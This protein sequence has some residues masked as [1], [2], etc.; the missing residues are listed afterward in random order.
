MGSLLALAAT[1][2]AATALTAPTVAPDALVEVLVRPATT[3]EAATG[4]ITRLG[5]EVGAL[6]PAVGLIEARVPSSAIP[7]LVADP[8]VASVD[9]GGH[10]TFAGHDQAKADKPAKADK[11]GKPA[12]GRKGASGDEA[13]TDAVDVEGPTDVAVDGGAGWSSGGTTMDV[14]NRTIG[15]TALHAQ[16]IDGRGI[17]IALVDTGVGDVPQLAGRW[18]P[19]I[20]LSLDAADPARAGRDGYGHGTHLAGIM[21][22]SG[23]GLTGVAPGARIVDVRVGDHRGAADVSQMVAAIDWVIQNARTGGRN[24]RVLNLAFGTTTGE[25][26][27][28]PLVVAVEAAQR[29]GIVVVVSAGNDGPNSRSLASP[30]TTPLAL[31]VGAS[32]T[33]GTTDRSD[34]T[35]AEFSQRG[36]RH[37]TPDLVAPGRSI[38]SVVPGDALV[39]TTHPDAYRGGLFLGSGTS[40]AAAVTSG[41]A[42]LLLQARPDLTPDALRVALTGTADSLVKDDRL[43]GA[44]LLDV[45]AAHVA[46]LSAPV[47][48]PE[49]TA[50]V[51]PGDAT[52]WM[53]ANWNGSVWA[54]ANW[55]EADWAGGN[56]NGGNWNGGNWNGGNWNGGNWNGGN[57]NEADWSG[58]NWNGGNWNGFVWDG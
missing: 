26:G 58:G 43:D 52:G 33:Q 5:G 40:Q 30:A 4:D 11:V 16:G 28:D 24:I 34:D 37:R 2:L 19:G 38:L 53:G 10:V 21:V 54:G 48:G 1:A 9:E 29:H 36:D 13:L 14:V 39:A 46:S 27:L 7:P 17:D 47:D 45:A 12:K 50:S 35:M 31:A 32:V 6:R 15:A 44:G 22:G 41:A 18:V 51:G 25:Q 42:A 55:N 3:V 56:W 23:A 8:D 57:W 49:M 20:D